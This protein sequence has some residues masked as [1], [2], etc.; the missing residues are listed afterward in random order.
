MTTQP[1]DWSI[2][3][4]VN[5][6]GGPTGPIGLPGPTGPTGSMGGGPTGPTGISGPTGVAGVTGPT[7]AAGGGGTSGTFSATLGN[8]FSPPVTGTINYMI[9][10]NGVVT[11]TSLSLISGTSS[12]G[13]LTIPLPSFLRPATGTPCLVCTR[14]FINGNDCV[15]LANVL[16]TSIIITPFQTFA[17]GGPETWIIPGAPLAGLTGIRQGWTITYPLT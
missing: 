4:A 13:S 6:G 1:F 8:N 14:I 5:T 11:L 15:C 3:G 17:S 7:G 9:D 16:V 12:D 2:D 10:G